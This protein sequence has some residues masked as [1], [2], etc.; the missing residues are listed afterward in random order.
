MSA[1]MK[2]RQNPM[3][4]S[5]D[6]EGAPSNETGVDRNKVEAFAQVYRAILECNDDVQNVVRSMSLII[7]DNS[8]DEETR[9]SAIDTVLEAM[10]PKM[11]D[12]GIGIDLE[13]I[14]PKPFDGTDPSAIESQ[15][16]A[17]EEAFA[18]RL[19]NLMA[20]RE[21]SQVQLAELTG[22]GQPAIS[23]MLA[24]RCRPQRRTILKFAQALGVSPE[25]LWTT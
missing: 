6:C 24:R 11:E 5:R 20:Q 17:Q 10:F 12:D 9:A 25:Q 21:V 15:M 4:P 1:F 13:K 19:G 22:V 23:N 3:P 2:D 16:A 7:S 14:G 18:T 8:V